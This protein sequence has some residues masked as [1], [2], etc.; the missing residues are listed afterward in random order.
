MLGPPQRSHPASHCKGRAAL[1]IGLLCGMTVAGRGF[2]QT[3]S[4]IPQPSSFPWSAASRENSRRISALRSEIAALPAPAIGQQSERIGWHST[5][6]GT[7]NATKWLQIELDGSPRFD[8]VTL[9][10]V[11]VA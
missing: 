2:A 6:S 10:P 7:V 8:A 4:F 5:F 3:P 9:V 1:L 11:D